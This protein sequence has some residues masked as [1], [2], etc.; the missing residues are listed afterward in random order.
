MKKI[1]L[2]I[3]SAFM[4]F[5]LYAQVSENFSDYTVG[6]KLAQ[7]AQGMGRMYWTTWSGA[8]GT[9]VDG[10]IA[11]LDG[12]KV[13]KFTY[14]ND[15]VLRLGTQNGTTWTP[16]T[17]GVWDLTFKI[18]VPT[19]KD[20]Y[21]NVLAFFN[22]NDSEW[23]VQVG[24]GCDP[25][26]NGVPPSYP[27][28]AY[29][30]AGSENAVIVPFAH[31]TWIDVKV[32]IDLDNDAAELYFNN[33][34]AHQWV[35]SLGS[36]GDGCGRLIDVMNIYPPSSVARSEFYI[37][38]INFA[39]ANAAS[40]LYQT[41]FDDV[42]AGAYVAQSYPTWWTTWDNH[43]GTGEDALITTEQ[44]SSPNNSAKCAYS[45]GTDL[46]FKAGDKTAGAYQIDFDMYIP[47]NGRAFF[48]V[49]HIFAGGGSEWAVGV[50]FNTST[51]SV[52]GTNIHQNGANTPFTFP[53]AT[54]FPV[55]MYVNLDDNIANI[56]INGT[57]YLEWAYDIN[58][59]GG[60]GTRQLA[61]VD[62]YPPQSG[63]VY[64]IDN[65]VYKQIGGTTF[66]ILDITPTAI[67]ETLPVGG[68]VTVPITIANNG[69]S[70]GDYSSSV[71]IDF[72][73]VAGTQNYTITHI[74]A[75][76]P[77]SGLAYPTDCQ[78]ELGAKFT[79]SD[80]CDKIGTKITTLSYYLSAEV[81]NSNKLIFRVYGPGKG[82][83]PGDML[84]E[85]TKNNAIPGMW[86]DVT[87][88]TPVLISK[89]EIW[90]SVEFQHLSSAGSI[91]QDIAE[92]KPGCNFTRR[93]AGA[94]SEFTQTEF[95]NFAIKAQSQGGVV[96]GC[97]I[98]LTG[99]P[100]G[101]VPMGGSKIINT[102]LNATGLAEGVYRANINIKTN[103]TEH[104]D[105]TIPC[106][107][108]VGNP[109]L[110]APIMNVAYETMAFETTDIE[111][112]IESPIVISNSGDAAG[113][114]ATVVVETEA[115]W[116]NVL[117]V[118]EGTLAAGEN[119]TVTAEFNPEG[120]E[121][122]VEYTATIKVT[123]TDAVHPEFTIPCKLKLL[124]EGIS[125]YMNGVETSVF[126]NPATDMITVKTNVLIN[127][128]QIFNNMGQVV[129]T[130]NVNGEI[131]TIN[132][133][134]LNAGIYFIKVNTVAGSQNVK[135][136]V[137]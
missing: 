134:N 118:L 40:V 82:N 124:P 34:L 115:G 90:I 131:T 126:P 114:Y 9:N 59:N 133:T 120:L 3:V 56:K 78:L 83:A 91:S 108:T 63:S 5:T 35:Y 68:N 112:I 42:A 28:Q 39:S 7:Q 102:V 81:G 47:A 1:L 77:S 44:A 117:G 106:T 122:E 104:L 36:F 121:I 15:Q 89:T 62:F 30:Y 50:Y 72:V 97:W 58:E 60:V 27:G 69:T 32:H 12:N 96:P 52:T 137:K 51:G 10:A 74:I 84:A 64:Y 111:T 61:A 19:G 67:N 22:G 48:N 43:P 95:S 16:K 119:V 31:D 110:P 88:P 53:Y 33:T 85:V 66:P 127:S 130:A 107:L 101:S 70:M 80:L 99:T 4:I 132:T 14:N 45:T 100:N 93:N 6:G 13:G 8:V 37:D 20:G 54:W 125:I 25:N 23:A 41:G 86:N 49:L 76:N 123:T 109:P 94:W 29:I 105:V 116:L 65:F 38:D 57:Q 113:D 79:G 11:E 46:V 128:I 24:M 2:S 18:R 75:E 98:S 73:P 17:T 71:E 92:L 129:Y 26:T 136:V 135:V 87:L 55:S 21:F 103:D